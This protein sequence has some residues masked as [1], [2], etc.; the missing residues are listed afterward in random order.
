[1]LS[2]TYRHRGMG[3][4][5]GMKSLFIY[6]LTIVLCLFIP[7]KVLSQPDDITLDTSL[8]NTLAI[9][10]P[11][12][13]LAAISSQTFYHFEV[14]N[15]E[16]HILETRIDS[17]IALVNGHKEYFARFYDENSSIETIEKLNNKG[18]WK[19]V[20][21]SDDYY[22]DDTYF[23]TDVRLI[24]FG[25][26][27][28]DK[29][30]IAT[31]KSVKRYK[32]PKYFTRV[33][34]NDY[35]PILNRS[36]SFQYPKG[37][38]IE[39]REFCFDKL[40][41]IQIKEPPTQSGGK[42][43]VYTCENLPSFEDESFSHSNAYHYPHLIVLT[44]SYKDENLDLQ[45]FRTTDDVYAWYRGLVQE[46]DE[47]DDQLKPMVQELTEGKEDTEKV[48]SIYYWIKNNI[49][50]IAFEDGVAG[51]K[52]EAA[53]SVLKKKYGD[54]KGMAN[55]TRRMLALA[56]FD[57][58]LAWIGTNRLPYDYSIPSLAVD[59]HMICALKW[60]ENF[61]YLD[62][63]D[64]FTGFGEYSESIQ[65][66]EVLI[67]NGENYIISSIPIRKA[68]DNKEIA[69]KEYSIEEGTLKGNGLRQY[70]GESKS[71]MLYTLNY[72]PKKSLQD[73][74]KS[75]VTN[76]NVNYK[77]EN[78]EFSNIDERDSSFEFSY[79][80]AIDNVITSFD[81]DIYID[82]NQEKYLID[83]KVSA[84][85][86]F[87]FIAPYKYHVEERVNLTIPE[88]YEVTDMPTAVAIN[89]PDFNISLQFIEQQG[90][91]SYTSIFSIPNSKIR[92]EHFNAWNE[93]VDKLKESYS[94]QVVLTKK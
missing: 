56:G 91:L 72:T 4:V 60:K 92:K 62:A 7:G 58:R 40:D 83:S 74:F 18:K 44:K 43:A 52:P 13:Y 1:M 17:L 25:L 49:R 88:G 80:I 41:I 6:R 69:I 39:F 84:D 54:C 73:Y 2:R 68:S 5:A 57:A 71:E 12:D 20:S 30:Q 47:E 42:S 26:M 11:E 27:F 23:H 16:I 48:R 34:F 79:N 15:G 65:G 9:R 37:L 24:Q 45:F 21:Y 86:K 32:D 14:V 8:A 89:N 70:F 81:E 50:Y 3:E 61:I 59:N 66:K 78:L 85:R 33:Y 19:T 76:G 55:L 67:E 36:L 51:Y 31:V 22:H 75:Y 29:G 94:H 82:L 77:I 87:D 53:S 64:K 28:T 10:Y 90:K 35:Y 63:T 38:D 93:A 46:V